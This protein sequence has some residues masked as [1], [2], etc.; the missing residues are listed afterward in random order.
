MKKNKKR[1]STVAIAALMGMTTAI[2]P[3][4]PTVHA[5]SMNDQTSTENQE[6]SQ[7]HASESNQT[8]ETPLAPQNPAYT[9]DAQPA[10]E[11]Q[12][13]EA[14]TQ[15]APMLANAQNSTNDVAID[16]KN[17]PDPVFRQWVMDNVD[18]EDATGK[19]DG[20]LTP[21][22]IAKVKKISINQEKVADKDKIKNLT[23][24][25]NFTALSTLYITAANLS[26]INLSLNI[27]LLFLECNKS[28]L[29][30]ISLPSSLTY[31][32]LEDNKLTTIDVSKNTQLTTL[33]LS[34][35]QLKDLH[36]ENNKNLLYLHLDN[37][38]LS[39]LNLE[40]NRKLYE[41]YS[42]NNELTYL[43]LPQSQNLNKISISSNNLSSIDISALP[44]LKVLLCTENKN[45]KEIVT[46]ENINLTTLNFAG[47][48]SF[49][50]SLYPALENLTISDSAITSLD[51]STNSNLQSLT[52]IDSK[53]ESIDFSRNPALH[54]FVA[55]TSS[56]NIRNNLRSINISENKQLK[57]LECIS[58]QLSKIDLSNN[59]NLTELNLRDNNFSS[60]DVSHNHNLKQLR[61]SDN[62]LDNIDLT[63]NTNL[64]I[65]VLSNNKFSSLDLSQNHSLIAVNLNDNAFTNLKLSSPTLTQLSIERNEIANLDVKECPNLSVIWGN[66]NKL[67]TLDIKDNPLLSTLDLKYNKL[68]SLDVSKNTALITLH[69][70]N[71]QLYFLDLSENSNLSSL[72]CKMNNLI[73]LN[74][75]QNKSNI[76]K[77][78]QNIGLI[79][80]KKFMIRIEQDG[81]FDLSTLDPMLSAEH[82]KDK[83]SNLTNATSLEGTIL[84]GITPEQNVTFT[85]TI[86]ET[87]P[88]YINVTL[89][90]TINNYWKED[91]KI[92]NWTYGE[93]AK[94]PS[95]I[96]AYGNDNIIFSYSDK[97][98]GTYSTDANKVLTQA[99]TYYVK[100]EATDPTHGTISAV[101]EF[102]IFKAPITENDIPK[103]PSNLASKAGTELSAIQLSNGWAWKES[104]QKV[105]VNNT[106]YAAY[107]TVDDTNYDYS[108]IEGY[109][110]TTHRVYRTVQVQ[111]TKA[112]NSW[113]SPLTVQDWMVNEE[114]ILPIAQA[115]FGTVSFLY[116]DSKDGTFTD[117]LPTTVGTWFVKAVVAGTADYTDLE[118]EILSFTIKEAPKEVR[119]ETKP[120]EKKETS[121]IVETSATVHTSPAKLLLVF[122]GACL[123]FFK[124]KEQQD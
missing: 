5:Q 87:V 89:G 12:H 118:S 123:I 99:G 73:A 25:E 38:K 100:A 43:K 94:K 108:S 78:A 82:L 55:R 70:E 28:N 67:T 27:N 113:T 90:T 57:T 103:L 33:N 15:E 42:S 65:L 122:L 1:N 49:D 72:Y 39:S 40:E 13:V 54:T 76:I 84:K 106:G 8:Q 36:L 62:Q 116:S 19:K 47:L 7:G 18:T 119:K 86:N 21:E 48:D 14:T 32:K 45:L 85:Y 44:K 9:K 96:A 30:N 101:K 88:Y 50:P 35:N 79:N 121:P 69:V 3:A 114:P 11:N 98:D 117:K 23:G 105:S 46:N 97:V 60:I 95:A 59:T 74:L 107:L 6:S 10:S 77:D 81:S 64:E 124:K 92:E 17:F 22:E 115:K 66:N 110:E 58:A 29:Q 26:S 93:T 4:F 68:T 37:N 109:D 2:N 83:V 91:L 56:F 111:V 20:I 71:N 51:L 102:Q 52:L 63:K 80:N 16:D 112:I 31:I 61:L 104:T 75:P 34:K 120:E 53:I 24:I 41:L